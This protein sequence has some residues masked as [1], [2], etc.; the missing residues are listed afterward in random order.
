MNRRRMLTGCGAGVGTALFGRWI[1]AHAQA[2]QAEVIDLRWRRAEEVVPILRGLVSPGGTVS[3]IGSQLVVR[4]DAANLAELKRVLDGIDRRPRRLLV[5]VKQDIE[6]ERTQSGAGVTGSTGGDDWTVTLPGRPG[7]P[8]RP[9]NGRVEPRVWNS[10]SSG[11]SR[12]GQSVQVLEGSSAFIATGQSVAV[13]QRRWITTPDG[14]RVLEGGSAVR[15]A[16]TGFTV[17]PRTS[18]DRVTVEI[19]AGRERFDDPASGDGRTQFQRVDT[20]VSGRL[21]EWIALGGGSA[22]RDV[23]DSGLTVRSS[24]A[25]RDARQ[26]F[27]KVEELP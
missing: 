2:M 20:V 18:G 25:S 15:E 4:T 7:D 10:R 13:P 27:L 21:G 16:S 26:M 24:D 6:T 8:A 5:T 22:T 17:R 23:D 14:V 3:A 12:D 19:V 9:P 11:T 1:G